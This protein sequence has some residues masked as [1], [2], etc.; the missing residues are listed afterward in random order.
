MPHKYTSSRYR[1]SVRTSGC[2]RVL[3]QIARS[4]APAQNVQMHYMCLDAFLVQ[5]CVWSGDVT[6]DDNTCNN[7]CLANV[8][9]AAIR[10]PDMTDVAFQH[11]DFYALCPSLALM[12]HNVGVGIYFNASATETVAAE[13]V[14]GL[15][16][17][18]LGQDA[19]RAITTDMTRPR[20]L[21]DD[22]LCFAACEQMAAVQPICCNADACT[23]RALPR[24]TRQLIH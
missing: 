2:R 9:P 1:T 20:A 10:S 22:S 21:H 23:A 18:A 19:R 4:R 11:D 13:E 14:V 3:D 7:R 15:V 8:Y 5:A 24:V 17:I 16:R 6:C 12:V